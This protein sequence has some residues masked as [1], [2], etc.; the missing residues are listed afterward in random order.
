MERE[1]LSVAI[2]TFNEEA[3][4]S[5]CLASVD[6]ADEIIIVD[7]GSTDNTLKIADRAGAKII[8]QDWLGFG[9]QKQVAV[10]HCQHDWVLLLDGDEQ[11]SPQARLV[12]GQILKG[13]QEGQAF[14]FPRKNYFC[15]QWIKGGGWWPDRLVRLFRSGEAK[16]SDDLVHETVQTT[17]PVR[18][19]AAPIIHHT[20]KNLKLTLE[21]QNVYSSIGADKLAK[22]GR[23]VSMFMALARASWAFFY[24]YLIRR[25]FMDGQAGLIIAVLGF[26]ISFFKYAKLYEINNCQDE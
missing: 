11:V 8:S 18:K 1:K 15:Q 21:K 12:I 16:V 9:P 22:N 10:S 25:G 20:N 7:C 5:A 3:C 13:E 19:L 26:Y 24:R 23:Q 14:S 4:L 17:G 2:I 6:F